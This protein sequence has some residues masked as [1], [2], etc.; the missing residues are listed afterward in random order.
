[1]LLGVV[2]QRQSSRFDTAR[3]EQMLSQLYNP[4]NYDSQLLDKPFRAQTAHSSAG[5]CGGGGLT[6]Y[7]V[8]LVDS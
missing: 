2:L 3:Y 7:C 1:M 8:R 5:E 6:M 4:T